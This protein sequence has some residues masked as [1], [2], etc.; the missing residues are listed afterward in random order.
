MGFINISHRPQDAQALRDA[1]KA[2]GA[3]PAALF[4]LPLT[5]RKVKEWVALLDAGMNVVGSAPVDGFVRYQ[6]GL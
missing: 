5:S 1:A 3:E 6:T 4:Y 2:A